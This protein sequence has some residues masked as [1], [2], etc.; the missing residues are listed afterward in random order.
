MCK[1]A[2]IVSLQSEEEDTE[3]ALCLCLKPP[4]GDGDHVILTSQSHT[5]QAKRK[6]ILQGLSLDGENTRG[7]QNL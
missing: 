2:S 4:E 5:Y 6:Y 3:V 1:P 7:H